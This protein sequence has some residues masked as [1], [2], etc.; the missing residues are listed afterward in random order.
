MSGIDLT[1]LMQS[2]GYVFFIVFM[3]YGQKIQTFQMLGAIAGKMKKLD[4][5]RKQSYTRLLTKLGTLSKMPKEEIDMN[6][7]RLVNSIAIPPA[8]VDPAGIVPKMKATFSAYENYMKAN[9]RM[10][11][12]DVTDSELQSLTCM[13]EVTMT[14]NQIYLIVDHFYKLGKKQGMIF[15]YQLAMIMGM[16]LEMAE[17]MFTALPAFEKGITELIGDSFGPLV[18]SKFTEGVQ[19]VVD[20]GAFETQVHYTNFDGRDL[21]VVRAKGPGGTVG[22]PDEAVEAILSQ[23]KV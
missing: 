2:A 5:Y 20:T 17:S 11:V 7:K 3:M 15:V 19:S 14:L 6:I 4:Q 8:S 1:T 10:I 22:G 9:L 16:I 12:P 13:L 18:A 21:Y 23:V